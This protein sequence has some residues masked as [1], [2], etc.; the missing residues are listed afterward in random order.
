MEIYLD[1]NATT[2]I[3]PVVVDRMA[4]LCRMGLANPASQHSAGRR[5]LQVFEEATETILRLV[6]APS[7]SRVIFTSGGTE[8][9]NLAIMGIYRSQPGVIVLGGVEHPSVVEAALA[10]ADPANVRQIPVDS[11]GQCDLDTLERWMREQTD[12]NPRIALVSVMRGNNETGI[13]Q[14]LLPIAD[15]CR[16]Y[17]V[18]FHSDVVQVV[19][20]IPFSMAESG[21]NAISITAHKMHGPTGIGALIVDQSTRLAPLLVGGGQQGGLRPGTIPVMLAAVLAETLRRICAERDRGAFERVQALR[22]SFEHRVSDL[23]STY[24]IGR[25]ARRLPHTTNIAFLGVD[26]QALHMS[27]DLQGVACSTGSACASGSA[28]PSPVLT[29]MGLAPEIVAGSLR[30]SLSHFTRDDEIDRALEI[31]ARALART[32]ARPTLPS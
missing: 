24:V 1:N 12:R 10:V 14:D 16:R 31:L 4:E 9:N 22:D 30:F 5:A 21:L 19:G 32:S 2:M 20:K 6:D 7:G 15:L 18:P 11:C 28:R 13:L 27:L 29:A 3:D 25:D 8:A 23:A 26:R 17:G